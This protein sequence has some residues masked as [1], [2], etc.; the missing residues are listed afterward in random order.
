MTLFEWQVEIKDDFST[1]NKLVWIFMRKP[2]GSDDI[3]Q[4]DFKTVKNIGMGEACEPTI[5]IQPDMFQKL[6]EAMCGAGMKPPVA[7]FNE[8]NLEATKKHLEDMRTLVF[9]NSS[10]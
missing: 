9:K 7:S 8:G 4:S 5:K 6:F 3:L 2:D 10:N 1:R